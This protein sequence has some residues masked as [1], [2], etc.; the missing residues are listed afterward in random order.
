MSVDMQKNNKSKIVITGGG[1]GG[2]TMTALAVVN[3]LIDK[4][5]EYKDRIVYL[6]G[7]MGMEGEKRS[8]SLDQRVFSNTGIEYKSIRSGK[9]HRKFALRTLWGLLGV[10]GGLIDAWSFFKKNDVSL[11]FSTGGYVSV[12]VCVCA[13][14]RKVPVIIHEQTTRVGLSNKICARFAEKILVGF[15]E[16]RRFFPKEKV[17]FVGNPIR[18]CITDPTCWPKSTVQKLRYFKKRSDEFPVVLISGGGQGSHMFNEIVR[19]SLNQLLLNYQVIL[20]CGDNLVYQ[21]HKCLLKSIK[22]S[23]ADFQKRIVV[24]KF[25]D[26]E[27]GAYYDAANIYVGRGGAMSVYEVGLL[28][29]PSIIIPIP[30]VTYNEQYHN[31]KVLEDLGLATIINQGELSSEVFV[32]RL[33]RFSRELSEGKID[34]D[35]R[36]LKQKFVKDADKKIVEELVKSIEV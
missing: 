31:S 3:R 35:K 11:V 12:P 18:K 17:R 27:M 5:P 26:K 33:H 7:S 30:W 23:S 24:E 15:E 1:S 13:G 8:D 14:L 16:S 32:Q 2:H 6:G 28:G 34:F 22:K 9:L 10:L 4:Y 29:I 19:Q 25:A 36:A 20:L 21:D